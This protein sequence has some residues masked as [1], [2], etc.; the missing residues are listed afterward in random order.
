MKKSMQAFNER[1]PGA[2]NRVKTLVVGYGTI[3]KE[4]AGYFCTA[5][6]LVEVVGIV[7]PSKA[8]RNAAVKAGLRAYAD[9]QGAMAE[10]QPEVV[11]D[12]SS[13]GQGEKNLEEYSKQGVKAVLQGGERQDA[14]PLYIPG[15]AGFEDAVRIPKCSATITNGVLKALVECNFIP[16]SLQ[17]SFYKA[18]PSAS[19]SKGWWEPNYVSAFEVSKTWNAL[20]KEKLAIRF[21]SSRYLP[22]KPLGRPMYSAD[23]LVEFEQNISE[24]TLRASLARHEGLALVSGAK[25]NEMPRPSIHVQPLNF[26]EQCKIPLTYDGV[27]LVPLVDQDAIRN[28]FGGVFAF[29]VEAVAPLIDLPL[30]LMAVWELAGRKKGS[31]SSGPQ[32]PI[33]TALLRTP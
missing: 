28:V 12:C 19:T 13:I 24:E 16:K 32:P 11:V 1:A 2:G 8:S 31:E 15:K 5:P 14:A 7:E 3:G 27:P 25:L 30:N 9:M 29:H 22:G 20:S 17:G 6:G 33:R 18:M 10:L 21:V 26:M 23:L 4:M